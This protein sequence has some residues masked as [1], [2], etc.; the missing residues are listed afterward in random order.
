MLAGFPCQSFSIAGKKGGFGDTRGTLF[1]DV[2]RILKF[3]QPI[4]FLLENVKGLVM[5]KSGQTLSTILS[6]L[7]DMGY[8]VKY[9][10]LN[11]KYF[12]VPQ[13]RERIYIVGF[14]E[15]SHQFCFPN[16]KKQ[17]SLHKI[18]EENPVGPKYYLSQ[19]YYQSLQAHKKRHEG[20]GNGYGYSLLA[21]NGIANT[22]VVG[23][24]GKERN[25]IIDK[26]VVHHPEYSSFPKNINLSY[27]R[28]LTPREWARLQGY[29]DSF[30]FPVSDTQ[31]YKQLGNSVTV[32]VITAIAKNMITQLD[33]NKR[34]GRK[35]KPYYSKPHSTIESY[36]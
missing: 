12:G 4:A 17:V 11:S 5:H 22:I 15:A 10:V 14:K 33:I 23:G 36:A 13:N 26:R 35:T 32:P 3:K 16:G 20:K 29:P 8:N 9:H 18:L 34:Y 31:S 7:Q 27:V 2:A 6:T 1:F 21:N 25:L 28:S 19:R 30:E 24:M